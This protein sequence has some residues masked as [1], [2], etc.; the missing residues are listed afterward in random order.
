MPDARPSVSEREKEVLEYWEKNDIFKKTVEKDAPRGAFV[1]YEGPPTANGKPGIHHVEA[2]AFKDLIPRFRTMQGYRVA[3][4]GGW[5]THGL[6]VELEVEKQLGFTG[7]AQIEEFGI[8]PFNEKCKESVWTYLTDWKEFTRRLGFWVDLD[9]AYVTYKPEYVE[10]LWGVIKKIWDRGLLYQDYRVT[11]HCPRCGTSLSSHEL[12]Q[13]YK[14]VKDISVYVKFKVI[15]K[16]T[17]GNE[18]LVAW[19]TTPW[20]LPSNVALAVGEDIAYALVKHGED[21]LWMARDLVAKLAPDGEIVREA[22][23]SALV[24]MEYEPLYPFVRDAIKGTEQEKKGWFVTSADFVTTTDGTGIVHT[25]VMYGADDFELGTKIGLPK[26]HL[27]KLDGTFLPSADFLAGRLVTD[28]GVAVDIIKDLAH[29]G[30]LFKKEKFEHSYPHCWRCKSKVIYYA[31]DSWY[32]RMSSLR[33]KLLEENEKINWE[34]SHIRDGRFGEWLREVKDWAFSRERYWGTP[35]PIWVCEECGDKQCVG[36][37]A[38][39]DVRADFDPHRPHVDEVVVKCAKC[40]GS[41]RRVKDVCDVWFDS[42]A[43]PYASGEYPDRYPADYICEAIDQTRGWFYTLL[44]VS[45]ALGLERPAKNIICLGHVLDAKGKK[46]SKSLGNIVRPM[47]MIDAYGADSVRW[48]MYTINQPGESKRFDEKT[49]VEMQRAVFGILGNVV[50][51]YE[52]YADGRMQPVVGLAGLTALDSWM[53][54][55]LHETVRDVTDGLE[56]YRVTEPARLIG[57]LIDDL[58]T[59][60]LRRSRDRFKSN[61]DADKLV[62][63]SVMRECLL[64][65]AK[66]MAPFAP[67]FAEDVYLRVGGEKPS[68]HLETW[69]V[70]DASAINGVALTQMAQTRSVVSKLLEARANAGKNVRQAL[71]S[72]TV[73]LPSGELGAEYVALVKDEVNVKA[74]LVEKGEYAVSLDVTLTPAL[75]REGT[76]REIVRRVNAMRKSGGLTIDDRIEVYVQSIEPEVAL[77]LEEHRDALVA[78]VL[79]TGLCTTGDAPDNAETFRANEFEMTVGFTKI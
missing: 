48:Y 3:R 33:D 14:D 36:S 37:F 59:W 75:V 30:L 66:L 55:R 60:W 58:S 19:T 67:F 5:D 61:D 17:D 46:M 54:A 18:Y 51:F 56:S 52:T 7:K 57:A 45:V 70:V 2:R 40:G 43:M 32:I 41:A 21:L 42:G 65:I 29:R 24:G 27:V 26:Y 72:A 68:V 69:P 4:K 44:A 76:V 62:A 10:G 50:S 63:L 49:L 78:G 31:K 13:G 47:E 71:A 12:A 9:N 20:T 64:T 23:G 77:A 11:P 16:E 28:E 53:L 39:L 22:Q 79:G 74:V 8:A 34:P 1:F 25:A 38:E 15:T 35:L 6:P 73:T